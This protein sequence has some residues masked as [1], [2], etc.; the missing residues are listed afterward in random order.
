[1]CFGGAAYFVSVDTITFAESLFRHNKVTEWQD[2]PDAGGICQ[3]KFRQGRTLGNGLYVTMYS[4]L[5]VNTT[6]YALIFSVP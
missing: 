6:T 3:S 1:V 5:E 4:L 2:S